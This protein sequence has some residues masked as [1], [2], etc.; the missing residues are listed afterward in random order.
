MLFVGITRASKYLSLVM[1]DRA[2]NLLTK[3]LV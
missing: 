2:E 3:R 1:S